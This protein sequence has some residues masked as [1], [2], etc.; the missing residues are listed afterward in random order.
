MIAAL[1]GP[2]ERIDVACRVEVA[3]TFESLHAHV[4]LDGDLPIHPG[5]EVTVHGDPI[6]PDFGETVVERR[7]AT[8][9][10]ARPLERLWTRLTG[11]LEFMELVDLSFTDRRAL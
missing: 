10:R 5:D 7:R 8:V 11:D 4:E 3:N 6:H 2:R 9:I 1:F